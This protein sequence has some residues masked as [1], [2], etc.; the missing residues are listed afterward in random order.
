MAF[1]QIVE[2]E[3]PQLDRV[4]QLTKEWEERTRGEATAHRVVLSQDRDNPR[5]FYELVFFDSYEEAMRNS[6]LPETDEFARKL[7]E[8]T[9][10]EPVFRNLEVVDDHQLG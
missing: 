8:I 9:E 1:I 3:T 4:Q 6:S 5:H 2:C 10:G 7:G